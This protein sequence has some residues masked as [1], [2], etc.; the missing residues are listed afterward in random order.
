MPTAKLTKRVVDRTEGSPTGDRWV[1]DTELHGL[2]LKVTP[3]GRRI[4]FLKYRVP[5]NRRTRKYTIGPYG[6]LTVDQARTEA[7]RL[8]GD[9]ATGIDPA[10]ERAREREAPLLADALRRYLKDHAGTWRPRTQHEYDRQAEQLIIPALGTSRV[11]EVTRADI[12]TFL[13]RFEKRPILGNRVLA[14]LSAFFTWALRAGLRS[15][16]INPA[17][18][19]PRHAERNRTRFLSAEEIGRL[20]ATVTAAQAG[21]WTDAEGKPLDRAP[22][23]SVAAITLLLF[24]GCRRSEILNL[25]WS[26]VDLERGLLLLRDTKAGESVRPISP[27][28]RAVLEQLPKGKPEARVLPGTGGR[29]HEIKPAWTEIRRVAKLPDV[30]LHDLRHTVASRSQHAGH[31]LLVT[32]SLLGHRNLA[33]TKKYAH[34][35]PEPV[36]QA[37]DRVSRELKALL[38]SQ[39]PS[40]SAHT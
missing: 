18:Y 12:A 10:R 4:F 28:T 33:T 23:Q 2:G 5:G 26:E 8:L 32:G 1:W 7:R 16:E 31:S 20:G 15:D 29:R 30:R 27:A 21:T 34:L 17:K 11:E 40:A 36:Q 35:I 37:A 9:V 3:N 38:A 13:R 14:L 6:P 39:S 25:R 22:W 24:T 19:L